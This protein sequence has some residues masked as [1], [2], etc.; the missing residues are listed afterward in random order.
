MRVFF[1]VILNLDIFRSQKILGYNRGDL[2]KS[3]M[4]VYTPTG[5]Y[6]IMDI[7]WGARGSPWG[8]FR[9]RLS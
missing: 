1:L 2:S 7:R 6:S 4:N 9:E 8:Y 5:M 3:H